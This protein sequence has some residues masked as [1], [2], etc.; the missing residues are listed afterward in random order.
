[1]HKRLADDFPESSTKRIRD[2]GYLLTELED[3]IWCL[4][5][6]YGSYRE[7]AAEAVAAWDR[8]IEGQSVPDALEEVAE[9]LEN[10]RVQPED[11]SVGPRVVQWQLAVQRVRL[12]ELLD[13][14][15][16]IRGLTEDFESL[17]DDAAAVIRAAYEARSLDDPEMMAAIKALQDNGRPGW[18]KT[19]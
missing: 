11:T 3:D 13:A 8:Y 14:K 4:S 19:K 5:A 17:R 2:I 7:A 10:L 1:M 12:E 16:I 18:W 15:Q 9:A 6:D